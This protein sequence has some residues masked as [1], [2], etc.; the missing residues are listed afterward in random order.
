MSEQPLLPEKKEVTD[1]Q[2][3]SA[4]KMGVD[5]PEV[6]RLLQD[7]TKQEEEKVKNHEDHINLDRKRAKIYFESGYKDAALESLEAAYE[8]AWNGQLTEICV[9]ILDEIKKITN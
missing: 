7:W 2:I 9:E 6:F 5:K 3:I 4:L 8:Q 1:E